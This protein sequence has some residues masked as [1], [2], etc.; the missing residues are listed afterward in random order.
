LGQQFTG[1]DEKRNRQQ[2]E[3]LDTADERQEDGFQRMAQ[4]LR[5]DDGVSS[6]SVQ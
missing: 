5:P 2:D 3:R 6:F 1:E 4:I